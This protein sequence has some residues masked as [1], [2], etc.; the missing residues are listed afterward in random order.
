MVL[1]VLLT[2]PME[3]MIDM[4]RYRL[5]EGDMAYTGPYFPYCHTVGSL[6]TSSRHRTIFFFD[7]ST[8]GLK[9]F[10]G[11][12]GELYYTKPSK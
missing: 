10:M 1:W 6:I 7:H 5:I 2:N 11:F 8:E 3:L 4:R 9:A 12:T